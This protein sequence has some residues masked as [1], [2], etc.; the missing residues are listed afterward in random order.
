M[1]DPAPDEPE[2]RKVFVAPNSQVAEAVIRVLASKDIAAEIELPP[3]APVSALTGM[4]DEAPIEEFPV[5]VT[6]PSKIKDALELL[7]AA[8]SV[9]AFKAIQDKRASRTGTVTAVC[10]D[11]GKSSD[12]PAQKMGTTENCPHCGGFMDIPD[13]DEDWSDMDVGTPEEDEEPEE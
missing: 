8:Q 12:W 3:P 2:S 6:D 9:A 4:S 10:E 1:A 7:G 11:C 5:V 13:P